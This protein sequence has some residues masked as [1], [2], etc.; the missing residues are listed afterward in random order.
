MANTQLQMTPLKN[1]IKRNN[2]DLIHAIKQRPI[3]LAVAD[4]LAKVHQVNPAELH[5]TEGR[6]ELL[7]TLHHV[8]HRH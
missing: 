3:I 2:A 1:N 6:N 5:T 8:R 7:N 4:T